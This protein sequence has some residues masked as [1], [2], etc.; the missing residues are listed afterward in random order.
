MPTIY[1]KKYT[2]AP[3]E[4]IRASVASEEDSVGRYHHLSYR[5]T[6]EMKAS[7]VSY[8]FDQWDTDIVGPFPMAIG[9][10]KFLLVMVN[11][12]SKW[13]YLLLQKFIWQHII[14]RFGIPPRLV[15]N[16][17]RHFA[18]RKLKEWCEEYDIQ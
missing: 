13:D 17:G 6:E 5:S 10:R 11:Y 7:I 14:Y 4:G 3:M 9:Q 12:F 2:K 18:G 15:S 1:C 16:N 8:S